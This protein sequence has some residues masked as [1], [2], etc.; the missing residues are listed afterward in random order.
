MTGRLFDLLDRNDRLHLGALGLHDLGRAGDDDRFLQL[1]HLERHLD[2][3]RNVGQ[4]R[5]VG[6]DHRLEPGQRDSDR[7]GPWRQRWDGEPADR[8]ADGPVLCRPSVVLRHDVHARHDA[9]L[10][11]HDHT[12]ERRRRA[13]ALGRTPVTL[14]ASARATS[15]TFPC[16]SSCNSWILPPP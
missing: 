12:R 8:V 11:V 5:D 4:Q 1:A 6:Q 15:K 16:C 9:T 10:F 3:L 7:I 13:G 14:I 2:R